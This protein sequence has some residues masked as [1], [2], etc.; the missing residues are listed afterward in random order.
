MDWTS[1]ASEKTVE[2]ALVERMRTILKKHYRHVIPLYPWAKREGSNISLQAHAGRYFEVLCVYA[3]RPKLRSPDD[4]HILFKFN[5]TL[6]STAREARLHGIATIAGCP[7]A[8][9]FFELAD[10]ERFVWVDLLDCL[11]PGVEPYLMVTVQGDIDGA[12]LRPPRTFSDAEVMQLLKQQARP[13]DLREIMRTIREIKS[14]SAGMFP[15]SPFSYFGGYRP[16][17]FLVS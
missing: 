5:D 9:D 17:Y 1:F 6:V 15:G 16:L 2:Y 8:R 13:L 14:A 10:C 11:S 7:I 3:R 4:T 12:A